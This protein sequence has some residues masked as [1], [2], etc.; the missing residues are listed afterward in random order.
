MERL[1]N[2]DKEIR[3]HVLLNRSQE[4]RKRINEEKDE[5]MKYKGKLL[6]L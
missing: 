5:Y 3:K 6:K 4:K 2:E 1:K